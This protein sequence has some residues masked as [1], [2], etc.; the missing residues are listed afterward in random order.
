M[1]CWKD[2][3]RHNWMDI[4]GTRDEALRRWVTYPAIDYA[5]MRKRCSE[6]RGAWISCWPFPVD[7]WFYFREPHCRYI[8]LKNAINQMIGRC[9]SLSN[10]SASCS[11]AK[12]RPRVIP[13][14]HMML[15]QPR[16]SPIPYP[17]TNGRMYIVAE[18]RQRFKIKQVIQTLPLPCRQRRIS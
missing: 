15:A 17:P 7:I 16:T 9:I 5:I 2:Y 10:L 12:D 6:R 11:S 8:S 14:N 13:P 3:A 18:G 1:S 4:V